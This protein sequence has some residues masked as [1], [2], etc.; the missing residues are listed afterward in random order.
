MSSTLDLLP[1]IIQDD[2]LKH[3]SI[4]DRVV[5]QR[6]G[7]DILNG[8]IFRYNSVSFNLH[9]NAAFW[10]VVTDAGEVTG[11]EY[12]RQ[13]GGGHMVSKNKENFTVVPDVHFAEQ[14]MIDF[15]ALFTGRVSIVQDFVFST[16]SINNETRQQSWDHIF[17]WFPKNS[18]LKVKNLYFVHGF[19]PQAMELIGAFDDNSLQRLSFD[20]PGSEAG[21]VAFQQRSDFPVMDTMIQY[22]HWTKA[23][24]FTMHINSFCELPISQFW[25]FDV[26]EIGLRD[27]SYSD[28][29]DL[30]EKYLACP[31]FQSCRIRFPNNSNAI[32]TISNGFMNDYGSVNLA[33]SMEEGDDVYISVSPQTISEGPYHDIRVFVF[34]RCKKV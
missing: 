12:N 6:T 24:I 22:P 32:E 17:K 14:A 27:L 10:N 15:A 13:D 11:V 23:K 4:R 16:L 31:N 33:F 19:H 2:I 25:H 1:P 18:S 29:H 34:R 21:S 9:L 26:C 30:M 28:A 5:L 20:F 7:R 8:K 3:T